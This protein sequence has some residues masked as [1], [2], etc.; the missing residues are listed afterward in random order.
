MK[1]LSQRGHAAKA[2][3]KAAQ[4]AVREWP[5]GDRDVHSEEDCEI[6]AAWVSR[7]VATGRMGATEGKVVTIGLNAWLKANEQGAGMRE[8]RALREL[9]EALDARQGKRGPMAMRRLAEA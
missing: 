2:A 6:V 4:L 1:A 3:K 8:N 9:L 5:L 7:L